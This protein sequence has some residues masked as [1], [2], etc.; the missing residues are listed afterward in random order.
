MTL[1]YD[2]HQSR[3]MLKLR[4]KIDS[5]SQGVDE[6]IRSRNRTLLVEEYMNLPC[7]RFWLYLRLCRFM[8]LTDGNPGLMED[9]LSSFQG[10]IEDE[11]T[12]RKEFHISVGFVTDQVS[13]VYDSLPSVV[14]NRYMYEASMM[15]QGGEVSLMRQCLRS[16]LERVRPE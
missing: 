9:A 4:I 8:V 15:D 10:G 1:L 2:L 14:L 6:A 13:A 16:L 12:Y 11:L 5:W 3:L 7:R